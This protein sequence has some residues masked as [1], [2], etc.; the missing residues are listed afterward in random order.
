VSFSDK[1]ILTGLGIVTHPDSDELGVNP[2]SPESPYTTDLGAWMSCPF[3]RS[4]TYNVALTGTETYPWLEIHDDADSLMPWSIIPLPTSRSDVDN[5]F[6]SDTIT[7][8]APGATPGATYNQKDQFLNISSFS[9][10]RALIT[11]GHPAIMDGTEPGTNTEIGFGAFTKF[12]HA[13]L[14]NLTFD[15]ANN[16]ITMTTAQSNLFGNWQELGHHN[17]YGSYI[18]I[19]KTLSTSKDSYPDDYYGVYRIKYTADSG[20]S[21]VIDSSYK[22]IPGNVSVVKDC[23]VIGDSWLMNHAGYN[24]ISTPFPGMEPSYEP[25]VG[26][27]ATEWNSNPKTHHSY[28][29]KSCFKRTDAITTMYMPFDG[30]RGPTYQSK[31]GRTAGHRVRDIRYKASDIINGVAVIGNIDT[32]DDKGQT[33]RERNRI[34]WSTPMAVDEFGFF[35]SKMIGV[36]EPGGIVSIKSF[37]GSIYCIK[38]N[39][40]YILNP[41]A[42]FAEQARIL[43]AGADWAS[44]V[45]RTSVGVVV[46]NRNGIFVLP[47]KEEITLPI[48]ETYRNTS[49]RNP[50]MGFSAKNNEIVFIPDTTAF[51]DHMWVFNIGNGGW[52]KVNYTS[53]SSI[54][55]LLYGGDNDL[56]YIK[57][58]ATL[59]DSE[60]AS[61]PTTF[62]GWGVGTNWT[63]SGGDLSHSAGSTVYT[64]DDTPAIATDTGAYYRVSVTTS[65]AGTAGKRCTVFVGGTPTTEAQRGYI[66]AGVAM[67]YEF[68]LVSGLTSTYGLYLLPDSD[69]DG[70][71]TEVS[72]KKL[73]YNQALYSYSTA[74]DN[75]RDNTKL[76]MHTKE[77]IFNEPNM[78]K[79]VKSLMITYLSNVGMTI[80]IYIDGVLDGKKELP[81][82]SILKNRKIN[83]NRECQSISFKIESDNAGGTDDAFKIEDMT[84]EGWYNDKK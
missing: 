33:F 15:P 63:L 34:M 52:V 59:S 31:T 11:C 18:N 64:R 46:A 47:S 75:I 9:A 38:N 12:Q 57:E 82:N 17:G 28:R 40:S 16:K 67:T 51:G 76:V 50:T 44:C 79:Y 8:I 78:S 77:F 83:I 1:Q 26:G 43:G 6:C 71:I 5:Y 7:I 36:S 22:A 42:G 30:T 25:D 65:A 35:R 53:G 13:D 19:V 41:A 66:Y 62:A 84:I 24:S 68:T 60:S 39:S 29:I 37:N 3:H 81:V 54:T 10:L 23:I 55:N 4:N 27:G 58:T 45:V 61:N 74:G 70:T 21:L 2:G 69:Y 73:D 14:D 48:K 20:K 72:C 56:F 32:L 49:F 80:Y